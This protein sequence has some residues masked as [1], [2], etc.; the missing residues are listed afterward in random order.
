VTV[1]GGAGDDSIG[2]EFERDYLDHII[3]DAVNGGPFAP[4]NLVGGEGNDTLRGGIGDAVLDGG[5]GVNDLRGNPGRFTIVEAPQ[6]QA[7]ETGSETA[8]AGS[9]DSQTAAP[10]VAPAR[11]SPAIANAAAN[12]LLD[13]DA[14]VLGQ[15]DDALWG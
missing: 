11:T 5:P 14:P 12:S 2:A 4:V 7:A 13:S 8:E 10:V 3:P 9:A 1:N 15:K 6:P